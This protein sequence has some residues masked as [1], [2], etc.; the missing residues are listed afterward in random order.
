MSLRWEFTRDGRFQVPYKV[1]IYDSEFSG[2]STDLGTV[3]GVPVEVEMGTRNAD[4]LEKIKGSYITVRLWGKK[5]DFEDL[6]DRNNERFLIKFY[7]DGNHEADFIPIPDTFTDYDTGGNFTN[8]IKAANLSLFKQ[9]QIDD[10]I[11]SWPIPIGPISTSITR[12]Q[13]IEDITEQLFDM[14]VVDGV[15]F[16]P[17]HVTENVPSL[18]RQYVNPQRLKG[19]SCYQAL[20]MLIP[21]GHQMRVSKGKI[22]IF[23]V[24]EAT[25]IGWDGTPTLYDDNFVSTKIGGRLSKSRTRLQTYDGV[26]RFYDP[27]KAD[28][29][30][31]SGDFELEDF[32]LEEIN[33]EDGRVEGLPLYWQPVRDFGL[34]TWAQL[35]SGG[36]AWRIPESIGNF[37]D[38]AALEASQGT[39]YESWKVDSGLVLEGTRLKID[40]SFS[41]TSVNSFAHLPIQIKVGNQVLFRGR[42]NF[43]GLVAQE[44]SWRGYSGGLIRHTDHVLIGMRSNTG[45]RDWS[46]VTPPVPATGR[47]TV[48]IETPTVDRS[49]ELDNN[50]LEIGSISIDPANEDGEVLTKSDILA[51]STGD[52]YEYTEGFGDGF[53]QFNPGALYDGSNYLTRNLITNWF[54]SGNDENVSTD[55]L[56]LADLESSYLASQLTKDRDKLSGTLDVFDFMAL[57]DG[58]R[59]N[60]IQT[61]FR[62]GRSIIELIEIREHDVEAIVE[63]RK[64]KKIDGI[65]GVFDPGDKAW[66]YNQMQALGELVEDLSQEVTECAVQL[67]G[68]IQS[69]H[70]YW[71]INENETSRE[72]RLDGVYAI[73]PQDNAGTPVDYGPGLLDG[74]SQSKLPIES[75]YIKAPKG[76]IILK[77]PGQ[78]EVNVNIIDV[79]VQEGE[80][81]INQL[82]SVQLPALQ[83]QLDTLDSELTTLDAAIDD[84]NTN[85]IPTLEGNLNTLDGKLTDL[86]NEFDGKFPIGSTDI[87]DGAI[88]TPKL[89]ANAI[90]SPKV[91]V[92]EL[93]GSAIFGDTFVANDGFIGSLVTKNSYAN[94]FTGNVAL[95]EKVVSSAGF[96]NEFTAQAGFIDT[97]INNNLWSNK[98]TSNEINVADFYATDATI[99][100]VLSLGSSAKIK[101]TASSTDLIIGSSLNSEK[102]NRP[103]ALFGFAGSSATP[104]VH[105]RADDDNFAEMVA[106]SSGDS[107]PFFQVYSD[108]NRVFYVDKNGASY[109]GPGSEFDDVTIKGTLTMGSSGEITNAGGD[110][111]IDEDGIRLSEGSVYSGS[112]SISWEKGTGGEAA[113]IWSDDGNNELR[114]ESFLRDIVIRPS[115]GRIELT[116]QPGTVDLNADDIILQ[117]DNLIE[118]IGPLK[119]SNYSNFGISNISSPQQGM[120]VWNITSDRVAYYDGSNWRNLAQGT[121]I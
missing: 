116:A 11:G 85:Q 38:Q 86:E 46:F 17:S 89:A 12:Q 82:N 111:V 94:T 45:W 81:A 20:E 106:R 1:E 16:H 48:E 60:Y 76:S 64:E 96:F 120:I 108:G 121:T 14:P 63:E 54:Y 97:M 13:V 52:L 68:V 51:G 19:L 41:Y 88:S 32:N 35:V 100:A 5:G 43:G 36:V 30:V 31:P 2:T 26:K 118:V 73:I 84:L 29:I 33:N 77:A 70:E 102:L 47:L 50:Y 24:T 69:G 115:N 91:N 57:I 27:L 66:N 71:I 34:T 95:M 65:A 37:A 4:P 59:V 98:I 53:T 40:L 10:I 79:R 55:P 3:G 58:Y 109:G 18:S 22:F 28:N 21:K 107:D 56:S 42:N 112:I 7:I 90:T 25:F 78:D 75:Q 23:P 49:Y 93:V 119:L 83:S 92:V 15:I 44:P 8:E 72:N 99:G 87:S 104:F 62:Y 80:E 103:Q 61:D 74:D 39:T 105:V 67:D 101:R 110:Y 9:K 113:R 117:A 6:F 114:I